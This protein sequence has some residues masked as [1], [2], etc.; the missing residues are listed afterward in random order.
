MNRQTMVH[1]VMHVMENE[2]VVIALLKHELQ[3]YDRHH[4]EPHMDGDMT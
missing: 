2:G 4:Q 1:L 3:K